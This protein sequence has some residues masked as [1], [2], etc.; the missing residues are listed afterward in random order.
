VRREIQ[1]QARL[2]HVNIVELKQV[3]HEECWQHCTT[4]Q[5]VGGSSG[6]GAARGRSMAGAPQLRQH[7]GAEAG[8]S[9]CHAVV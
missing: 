5:A 9:S 6:K 2:S 3:R 4:A 7:S 8:A 1:L